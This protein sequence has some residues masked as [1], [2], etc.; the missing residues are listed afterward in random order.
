MYMFS[1]LNHHVENNGV[2]Q[3]PLTG[4]DYLLQQGGTQGLNP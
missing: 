2:E 1:D 4:P 3:T